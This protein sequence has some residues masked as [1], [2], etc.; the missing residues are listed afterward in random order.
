MK[1]FILLLALILLCCETTFA[2]EMEIKLDINEGEKP[3]EI[4]GADVYANINGKLTEVTV[5]PDKLPFKFNFKA[6]AL[7]IKTFWATERQ[8]DSDYSAISNTNK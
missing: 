4:I 5:S 2:E 6:G 1:K 7:R 3:V 8:F